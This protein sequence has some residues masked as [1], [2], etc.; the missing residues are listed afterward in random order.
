MLIKKAAVIGGGAM[1]GSIAHL[2]TSV[3]IECFV[4]DIDQKFVD[5]AVSISKGVYDKLVSKGKLAADKAELKQALLKGG[6]EYDL[7]YMKDVDL[8]IEAVPEILKLKKQIFAELDK[9][10][11][12]KTILASNTS[13]LSL[14]EIA[15]EIQRKDR[16]IGLHFFNPAHVMKLM[17]V[18]YDQNTSAETL[19]EMMKFATIID[20]VAIKCKNAPGFV[21]NRILIPYMNEALLALMDG[22][23]TM[24]EIDEA[25]VEFGMP[26]GPFSLWDLVGLDVAM[27]A[28]V[29]LEEAFGSRTPVPDILK[30]MV[31]NKMFGQKTGKGFYDYSD[32]SNK[33]VNT[34]VEKYLKK[35]WKEN[36]PASL[37]FEP[38]RLLAVQAREALLIA[39]EEVAG[40][41]DIDTGMVYGTNFPTK[42]A[43]G[44]LHWAE[45]VMGWSNVAD[46][47]EI[48]AIEVGRE[49]FT[50]PSSIESLVNG[51]SI[52]INCTYEVDKNRIALVTVENPPMNVLSV[53]TVNDISNCMLK[54]IADPSV[55]VIV[56]TGKGRAFVAG[57][58]IKEFQQIVTL[59]G[60]KE[61]SE[62]GQLMTNIIEG[63]D[64][65]VICAINGFALGG[66]LELAMPCHIRIAAD[67]AKLGLPEI[68]LGII[69]GF[70]GTQ[71]LPRIVGKAKGIEMILTGTPINAQ[72][73]LAIGLVNKV[74]P[75]ASLIDEAKGLAGILAK[76]GRIA[77]FSAITSVMD[78]YDESF[79]EGCAIEV[80]NFARVKVS[81]D[82]MEGV[83][84]FL[85]KRTAKFRDM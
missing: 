21:V 34:E 28:S 36:S 72:E 6:I 11:P 67:S 17:E 20:K 50:L 78:G 12:E 73:A 27:H 30:V 74:V 16:F 8:I 24:E 38:E 80:E 37:D 43:Y 62:R 57:A 83:D 26:M 18:I 23:G 42:V 47:A 5:K 63:S 10:C 53:K 66:G 64:K 49:R 79:E 68:N 39:A 29:T 1:G 33:V 44:P 60:A 54:A 3:G 71:R 46:I 69:P 48:Y 14:T 84:A 13:S 45:E 2:L 52:F 41:H 35:L 81:A 25:M 76:K 70:A 55:R 32:K 9:I 31:E 4:K 19:E 15:E 61:Y 56:L 77:V 58:D 7:E 85:T 51:G 59:G 82:A 75:L 22:S 65:P 40:A